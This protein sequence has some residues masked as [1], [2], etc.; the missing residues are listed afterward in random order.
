[1]VRED[2][3]SLA[4]ESG[5]KKNIQTLGNLL[6]QASPLPSDRRK[7][8]IALMKMTTFDERFDESEANPKSE[9]VERLIKPPLHERFSSR[10]ERIGLD[11]WFYE[12]LAVVFS[13]SCFITIFIILLVYNQ[14]P[15]PKFAHGI[16]LNTIV[17]ALATASKSSLVFV[18]GESIGQLRWVWFQK[19]PRPLSHAQAY[20]SASR[21][22]WGS[23]NMLLQD[24][25]RS[26]VSLGAAI[27]ILAL[28]FD[29]FVQQILSY[30]VLENVH[31]SDGAKVPRSEFILSN[32]GSEDF[33]N[34]VN[35]G[36]WAGD[37]PVNPICPS[38]NCTWL[39]FRSV[40]VCSK[41]EDV[42]S[43]AKLSGCTD[44][45]FDVKLQKPQ[46]LACNVTLPQGGW[47]AYPVDIEP[48]GRSDNI[49]SFLMNIPDHV[50]WIVDSMDSSSWTKESGQTISGGEEYV[51]DVVLSNSSYLGVE[52][53]LMVIAHAQLDIPNTDKD[54]IHSHPEHGVKLR[55]VTECILSLCARTYDMNVTR[56]VP[57][58]NVTDVDWGTFFT[59]T[60]KQS[61]GSGGICWKPSN[62]GTV[63]VNATP[64]YTN[65]DKLTFCPVLSLDDSNLDKA[66]SGQAFTQFEY[67]TWHGYWYSMY[68]SQPSSVTIAK[69]M[70]VGLEKV[71]GNV[72]ASLTNYARVSSN[73]F[74][75][76]AMAVSESYVAVKWAWL[77]LPAI[78]LVT[79]IA[80]LIST[81]LLN[82]K[83]ELRLWKSS[84]LP[85]LYHGVEGNLVLD[86]E[87]IW[88]VSEMDRNAKRVGV[89][90]EYS[91][92][93]GRVMLRR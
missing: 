66:L 77:T 53:P 86:G 59:R 61:P 65:T 67:D 71:I 47:S 29:P 31:P 48:F 64:E 2:Q 60:Y 78:L 72:A 90:L 43:S 42:T 17:S 1:M 87:R 13:V 55:K 79:G 7:E 44:A 6:L 30:P 40:E 21:G 88:S 26:L 80:F 4:D 8:K 28:V 32:A 20:D 76:G 9:S 51:D 75:T 62:V 18:V 37:F 38:G 54:V 63:N 74:A 24:R 92:G 46:P 19:K 33:K 5:L 39:P 36:F 69:I 82:E 15:T 52:N 81:V 12:Y 58:T 45:P 34:A 35:I 89:R 16:T 3:Y 56:G 27:T 25:G 73:S 57:L 22:P 14:K 10:W 23:W 50:M 49:S 85:V 83:R 11:T 93:H 41:C 70:H 84:V 91:D 68:D